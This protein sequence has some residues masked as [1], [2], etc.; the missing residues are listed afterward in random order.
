MSD[1]NKNAS[2]T[3]SQLTTLELVILLGASVIRPQATKHAFL[4]MSNFM[5]LLNVQKDTTEECNP[6]E[7]TQFSQL[8]GALSWAVELGRLDENTE[9]C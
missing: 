7:S 1:A 9:V 6:D 4:V 8:V 5:F 3:L 2:R